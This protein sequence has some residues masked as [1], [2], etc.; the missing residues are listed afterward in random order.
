MP[1]HMTTLM[2]RNKIHIGIVPSVVISMMS[3]QIPLGINSPILSLKEYVFTTEEALPRR[4][5]TVVGSERPLD[6]SQE[7]VVTAGLSR[8]F[9]P[10]ASL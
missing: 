6:R 7:R 4:I 9:P 10:F 5:V 2:S 1:A 8:H 3:N